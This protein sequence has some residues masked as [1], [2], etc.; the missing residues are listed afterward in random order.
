MPNM[1]RPKIHL[2]PEAKREADRI[3]DR[4]YS[5]SEKGKAATYR[6]NH[7][8]KRYARYANYRQ[9]EKYR[10]AQR[11]YRAT[12]KANAT[13]AAYLAAQRLQ[14][15]ERI[16]ARQAIAA[17]IRRGMI[18]RPHCCATCGHQSRLD[19]HH[20]LGYAVEHWLSVQWLC[21]I[22]HKAAHS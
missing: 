6:L 1:G 19:A 21:R 4:K 8:E 17:L 11:R 10:E 2:T 7:S 22:C 16:R 12:Q 14:N 13:G 3:S 15:P 20:Y 18:T 9:T 5:Q